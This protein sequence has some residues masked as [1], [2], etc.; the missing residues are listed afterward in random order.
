MEGKGLRVNM[1]KTTVLISGPGLDVLQKSG[2]Y[3]CGVCLMGAGTNSIFVVVVPV[4]ST[5][6]AVTSLAI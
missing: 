1:G 5:R 2:K 3:P 6:N 4:G